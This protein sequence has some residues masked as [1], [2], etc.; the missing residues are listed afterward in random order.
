[1]K[2][3][4]TIGRKKGRRSR[5]TRPEG[6]RNVGGSNKRRMGKGVVSAVRGD[7]LGYRLVG[8]AVADRGARH[9]G[10]SIL[11]LAVFSFFGS[12]FVT[13]LGR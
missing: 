2:K 10:R 6:C 4:I 12:F 13:Q 9:S 3:R 5:V 8:S 7:E 11:T 1:M